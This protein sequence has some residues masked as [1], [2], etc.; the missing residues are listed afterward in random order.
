MYIHVYPSTDWCCEGCSIYVHRVHVIISQVQYFYPCPVPPQTAM[1]NISRLGLGLGL[2]LGLWGCQV[3]ISN[4]S[5][6]YR[7]ALLA[8]LAMVLH[9]PSS[10]PNRRRLCHFRRVCKVC[11]HAYTLYGGCIGG[12]Q[13]LLPVVSPPPRVFAGLACRLGGGYWQY[14]TVYTF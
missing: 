2:G 1:C 8:L 9:V 5:S 12:S 13:E 4:P 11:N 6:Q 7:G 10:T 3:Y 14:F